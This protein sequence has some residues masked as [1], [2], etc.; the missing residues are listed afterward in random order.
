M[1]SWSTRRGRQVIR[2]YVD[3]FC[4]CKSLTTERTR[5]FIAVMKGKNVKP[6]SW[7]QEG[8][9]EFRRLKWFIWTR[10]CMS[11]F[12]GGTNCLTAVF[13]P[14]LP[15]FITSLI[16][17]D[18]LLSPWMRVPGSAF[19]V[20][21]YVA[22]YYYLLL[23]IATTMY[24]CYCVLPAIKKL[25]VQGSQ[26]MEYRELYALQTSYNA[27]FQHWMSCQILLDTFGIIVNIYL[28]V[29][30]SSFRGLVVTLLVSF[31]AGW[32]LTEYS[33]LHEESSALL[34]K[35][36]GHVSGR[37]EWFGRFQRSCRPINV[38]NGRA[39][40]VDRALLL[41]LATIIIDKTTSLLVLHRT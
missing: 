5:N 26:W 7:P 31:S 6:K 35:W 24:S 12:A 28:A 21:I 1:D 11:F 32:S 14:R 29:I 34:N 10:I 38:N 9:R 25:D 30:L 41:T 39:F 20:Y 40:Y 3:Y 22:Q 33:T 23:V 19:H 13:K 4:T 36:A 16:P 37:P 2:N 17:P 18:P 15:F 27:I 8:E